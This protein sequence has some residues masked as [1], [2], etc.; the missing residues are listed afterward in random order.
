LR[1]GTR[2]RIANTQSRI[3][4]G[5]R[6]PLGRLR[7]DSPVTFLNLSASIFSVGPLALEFQLLLH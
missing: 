1:I 3:N 6:T 7:L 5:T 2:E 4:R